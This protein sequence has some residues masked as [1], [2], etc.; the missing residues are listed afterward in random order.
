M[1][2]HLQSDRFSD[3]IMLLLPVVG[4]LIQQRVGLGLRK[5][6]ACEEV[7][8]ADGGLL[9]H[10]NPVVQKAKDPMLLRFSTEGH[11]PP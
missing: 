11:S 10:A 4:Q 2:N 1:Y 3:R 9:P 7:Q 6:E 8:G 5:I